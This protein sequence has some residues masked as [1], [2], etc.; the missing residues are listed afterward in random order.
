VVIG[1]T[2]AGAYDTLTITVHGAGGTFADLSN[3]AYTSYNPATG[4]TSY[5]L[6]AGTAADATSELRSL[7]FTAKPGTTTFSLSDESDGSTSSYYGW[8]VNGTATDSTT[9]LTDRPLEYGSPGHLF[10]GGSGDNFVFQNLH[11][12]QVSNPTNIWNFAEHIDLI[13]LHGLD[14]LVPGHH[15]LTFIGAQSF[16]AYHAHHPTVWGM[17]RDANGLVQVNVNHN[18]SDAEMAIHVPHQTLHAF[19]FVL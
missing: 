16:A 14:A 11:A 17:V 5:T 18:L 8:S 9:S 7:V 6:A 2:N 15:H 19:D 3:V 4:E 13:D 12:S 10:L 1:D